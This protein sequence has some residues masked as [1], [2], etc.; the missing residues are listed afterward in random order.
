MSFSNVRTRNGL[1]IVNKTEGTFREPRPIR[2]K[3][4]TSLLFS[5]AP[6]L[7]SIEK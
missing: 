6:T 2:I 7:S 3:D 4:C 1:A 5:N